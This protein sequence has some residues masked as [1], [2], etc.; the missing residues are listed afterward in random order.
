MRNPHID[1]ALVCLM[2]QRSEQQF[3]IARMERQIGRDGNA[4][5]IMGD[6]RTL[7]EHLIDAHLGLGRTNSAITYLESLQ[8]A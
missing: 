5:R 8:C 6:D 2:R 7:G 3:D 1:L 4:L